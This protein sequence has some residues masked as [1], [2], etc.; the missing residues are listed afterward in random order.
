MTHRQI[1]GLRGIVTGASGGIGEAIARQL[2]QAGARVLLVAR[3][4][5]RLEK[6]VADLSVGASSAEVANRVA[7]LAGDIT[8]PAVRT[9]AVARGQAL[10][11]GLDLLVNNAGVGSLGRF[12]QSSPERLR[13][14][15][16]VNFFAAVE[17]TRAALPAMYAGRTPIVVNVGSILA[18]RAIPHAGEYCASKFALRGFSESLRAELAP[19]GIDV[20]L[21]TPGSTETEFFDHA[22]EQGKYPWQQPR[23]V[24][25]DVVARRTVSAIRRGKHEVTIGLNSRLLIW[26]NRLFPG[27]VDRIMARYG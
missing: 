17:L 5:D 22:L 6:I 21:V 11:G 1:T 25:P 23:G 19:R 15:M 8:D 2:S 13:Q 10:F 12:E 26:A 24:S 4:A 14:V 20:L 16:E 7:L 18:H 9:E 3:R 27:V